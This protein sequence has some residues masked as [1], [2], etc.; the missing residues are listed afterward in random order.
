MAYRIIG[1]TLD[2]LKEELTRVV[3]D[4]GDRL[5]VIQGRRDGDYEPESRMVTQD[6]IIFDDTTKGMVLKD[7]GT[8]PNFWRV[9]VDTAGALHQESIG[10]SL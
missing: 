3:K 7:D 10:G 6:D 9:W 4:I 8:P 5:D 2:E 1:E